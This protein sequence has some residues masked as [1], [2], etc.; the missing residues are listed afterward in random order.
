MDIV[1]NGNIRPE[2]GEVHMEELKLCP[3]C[4]NEA[5]CNNVG[6]CDKDSNSLWWVECPTCGV[7]TDGHKTPEEAIAVW[8]KRTGY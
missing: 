5:D 4:G 8:N 2:L 3:F 6:I 1:L 7:S